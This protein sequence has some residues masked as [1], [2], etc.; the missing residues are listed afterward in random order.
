MFEN[1]DRDELARIVEQ[2]A[3][4]GKDAFAHPRSLDACLDAITCAFTDPYIPTADER[5]PFGEEV[6][7]IVVCRNAEHRKR[8]INTFRI[9][10]FYILYGESTAGFQADKIIFFDPNYAT[11]AAERQRIFEWVQTVLMLRLTRL[12]EFIYV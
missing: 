4:E 9:P 2:V 11:P 6:D 3:E 7:T 12:G 8:V 5:Y 10:A 1:V